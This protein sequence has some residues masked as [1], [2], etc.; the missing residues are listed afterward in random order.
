MHL[1]RVSF[2]KVFS[3]SWQSLGMDLI[4]DVAHNIA[5][6]EE[7]TVSG[8][9]KTLCVHRKGA[10]RA[11]GPGN[12][13]LPARYRALGQP[14]IIPGDMG[15]VSY[16]LLGTKKAETDTFGSTCHGAG[17]VKSRHEAIRTVNLDALIK[18][19]RSKGIEVR[20]EG[21]QTIVEEA[22]SAYKNIDEVIDVV[23]KAG[24]SKKVCRMRPLCVLKG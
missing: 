20:A 18:E 5:K 12:K 10:T 7:Y 19:L 21:K 23:D 11:F 8:K 15:R 24:L 9:K 3:K 13:A 1:T 22:P 6:L 14:V 16:L 2:E 4:Y 17:R